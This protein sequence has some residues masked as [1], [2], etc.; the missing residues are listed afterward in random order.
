VA[1]LTPTRQPPALQR[2]QQNQSDAPRLAGWPSCPKVGAA[3]MVL[4]VAVHLLRCAVG[5]TI[6]SRDTLSAGLI[7]TRW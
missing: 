3:A 1:I 6:L 5:F 4:F 2:R 7:G